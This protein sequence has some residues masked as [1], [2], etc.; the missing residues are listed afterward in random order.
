MDGEEFTNKIPDIE[1]SW[2]AN[3]PTHQM[4]LIH[5]D[6]K[7][8]DASKANH[9]RLQIKDSSIMRAKLLSIMRAEATPVT[10][11]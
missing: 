8:F 10:S 1:A 7:H 11:G 3:Q 9:F 6:F 5:G 4:C 2:D